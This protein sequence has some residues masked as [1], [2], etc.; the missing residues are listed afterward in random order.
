MRTNYFIARENCRKG[1]I[2]NKEKTVYIISNVLWVH[3]QMK[4]FEMRKHLS[5][6]EKD[7]LIKKE[8]FNVLKQSI[9]DLGGTIQAS[10]QRFPLIYQEVFIDP[11]TKNEL[12][13]NLCEV[14]W[15]LFNNRK[16]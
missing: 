8:L 16:G 10:N 4:C 13:C 6:I 9:C 14:C 3:N 11:V 2:C 1:C 5:E 7:E 12:V 15:M